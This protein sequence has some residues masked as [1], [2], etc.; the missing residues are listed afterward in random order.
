MKN[1]DIKQIAEGLAVQWR[2]SME[3]SIE[4]QLS[5][6]PYEGE[7]LYAIHAKVMNQT[8]RLIHEQNLNYKSYYTPNS[9]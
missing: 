1:S 8:I 9:K 6:S 4:W 5:D 2:Q 7:Q 3:E